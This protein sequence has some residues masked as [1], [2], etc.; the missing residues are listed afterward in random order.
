MGDVAILGPGV[1]AGM[2]TANTM[3]IACEA[4]GMALPGSTPIAANSPQMFDVVRRAGARIVQMV[5][6][7]LKPRDILTPGAFANAVRTILSIGGSVQNIKH[8]QAIA[9]EARCDAD[10]YPLFQR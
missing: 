8:P 1:C 9:N 5:W 4:L 2:G 6:D 7:D 3:H 10:G